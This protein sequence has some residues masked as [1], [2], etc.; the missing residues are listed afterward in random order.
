MERENERVQSYRQREME[1]RES[2]ESGRS[3]IL[4][5]LKQGPELLQADGLRDEAVEAFAEGALLDFGARRALRGAHERQLSAD[6][7]TQQEAPRRTVKAKM[8]ARG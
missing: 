7:H 8:G 2:P 4:M 1:E 5:R 6:A 3:D